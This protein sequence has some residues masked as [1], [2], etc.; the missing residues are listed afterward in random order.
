ML[1]LARSTTVTAGF[2]MTRF[3]L[4][5][6]IAV[7]FIT[8]L[9]APRAQAAV[10][11]EDMSTSGAQAPGSSVAAE[12]SAAI[13]ELINGISTP[14][15]V[16]PEGLTPQSGSSGYPG[17]ESE[18]IQDGS[19]ATGSSVQPQ[20]LQPGQNAQLFF[21]LQQLQAELLELRG[22]VEEQAYEIKRLQNLQRSQY[23]DIDRRLAG[24]DPASASPG[25][26]LAGQEPALQTSSSVP[27]PVPDPAPLKEAQGQQP[28]VLLP[29]VPPPRPQ[30]PIVQTGELDDSLAVAP[31]V[32][33]ET[34]LANET[35]RSPTVV[36][37]ASASVAEPEPILSPEPVGVSTEQE[38]YA[39]AFELMKD[40]QFEQ[41]IAA[42]LGV[43][44]E[45]PD[46]SYAPES[47]YWLGELYLM[48]DRLEDARGS[49]NL[50]VAQFPAHQKVPLSLY[51]LG[52]VNHRLG[53]TTEALSYLDDVVVRYPDTPAAGLART[54]AAELR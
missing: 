40:Q 41:S 44:N 26:S 11:V 4:M 33:E 50:V 36:A 46:G 22:V 13:G 7:S 28:T 3:A 30:V 15:P 43:I 2:R 49:F 21:E 52:V 24:Q 20:Q 42:Y 37:P 19:L 45:F 25:E 10:P 1:R 38:A 23:L 16:L 14:Q 32:P 31:V 6:V 39:R 54:Y 27:S 5:P 51:K 9:P 18:P 17:Y 29:A 35:D 12:G 53:G 34:A 47:R 48:S 8:F